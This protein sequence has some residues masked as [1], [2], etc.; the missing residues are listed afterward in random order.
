MLEN[1]L[2]ALYSKF[3]K[4]AF[5]PRLW[6][7]GHSLT[8]KC[9]NQGSV[10]KKHSSPSLLNDFSVKPVHLFARP[11]FPKRPDGHVAGEPLS[12]LW[13]AC[14][15]LTDDVLHLFTDDSFREAERLSCPA[16]SHPVHD[17]ECIVEGGSRKCLTCFAES[18]AGPP[19][20]GC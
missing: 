5:A 15:V 14:S 10:P 19:I 2:K 16:C 17:S 8:L 18:V 20:S 12:F 3:S 6:L 11:S 1:R 4:H 9:V 7:R 13:M